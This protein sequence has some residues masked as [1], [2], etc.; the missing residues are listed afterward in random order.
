MNR[1]YKRRVASLIN[2]Y[3]MYKIMLQVYSTYVT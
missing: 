1:I 2:K 3:F